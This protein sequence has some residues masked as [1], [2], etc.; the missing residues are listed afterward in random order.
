M[1][2]IP[3][4]YRQTRRGK[5]RLD[6]GVAF[7]QCPQDFE[8]VDQEDFLGNRNSIFFKAIQKGRD[9]LD[10]C[11]FAG[12]NAV[13]LLKALHSIGGV[14][15]GTVTEDAWGKGFYSASPSFVQVSLTYLSAQPA[16]C[17]IKRGTDLIISKRSSRLDWLQRPL[18]SL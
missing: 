13:F 2:T 11:A 9:G 12:T 8:N 10:S 4:F 16:F 1:R 7:L 14:P 6:E 17:C 18:L 15:Y 5:Y 3:W